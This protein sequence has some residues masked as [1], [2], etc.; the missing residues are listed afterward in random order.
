MLCT[1]GWLIPCWCWLL[2]HRFLRSTSELPQNFFLLQLSECCINLPFSP[3][4]CLAYST[5]TCLF[6][7][8]WIMLLYIFSRFRDMDDFLAVCHCHW[9]LFHTIEFDICICLRHLALHTY[10]DGVLSDLLSLPFP[11]LLWHSFSIHR[12]MCK[13]WKSHSLLKV[14]TVALLHLRVTWKPRNI[15]IWNVVLPLCRTD[16]CGGVEF[17]LVSGSRAWMIRAPLFEC[18]PSALSFYSKA[19][20]I[21]V[22][23]PCSA[24]R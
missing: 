13:W 3:S 7:F 1:N 2:L 18:W 12:V 24:V 21:H 23:Y 19:S 10:F 17:V 11:I 14:A 20:L 5:S 6:T 9:G 16:H 4:S 15:L 8:L 22:C